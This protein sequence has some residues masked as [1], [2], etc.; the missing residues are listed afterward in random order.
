MNLDGGW[1][2]VMRDRAKLV[3]RAST[4]DLQLAR[5]F[6]PQPVL[7]SD[8]S[9]EERSTRIPI[10]TPRVAIRESDKSGT[11]KYILWPPRR[12]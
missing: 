6:I 5:C 2:D 8:A 3:S 4:R 9:S 7:L 11:G 10:A 1:P 12:L